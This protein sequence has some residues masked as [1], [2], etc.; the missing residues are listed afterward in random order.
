MQSLGSNSSTDEVAITRALHKYRKH[1]S[2][3]LM[4]NRPM[5]RQTEGPATL[6]KENK[7]RYFKRNLKTQN[8]LEINRCQSAQIQVPTDSNS[9]ETFYVNARVF[10]SGT[11]AKNRFEIL[12]TQDQLTFCFQ[13][14]SDKKYNESDMMPA[15]V[16]CFLRALFV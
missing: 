11:K 16:S 2:P 4:R 6:S 7:V 14:E 1:T 9:R 12:A 3:Y 5:L 8:R 15:P 10:A 13:T